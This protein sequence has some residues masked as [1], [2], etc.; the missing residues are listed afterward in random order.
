VLARF[1]STTIPLFTY[2]TKSGATI[3]DPTLTAS[4]LASVDSVDVTVQVK[5]SATSTIQAT[6]LYERVTLPNAD[7]V[8]I[9]TSSP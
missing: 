5:S 4:D 6:T 8:A 2:Y 9:A 7:A 3:T 1:V